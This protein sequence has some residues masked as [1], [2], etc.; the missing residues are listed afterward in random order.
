MNMLLLLLLS[1]LLLPLNS[2]SYTHKEQ[3]RLLPRTF[4]PRATPASLEARP[5]SIGGPCGR[6]IYLH[7]LLF[8]QKVS[9]IQNLFGS[10]KRFKWISRVWTFEQTFFWSACF[11]DPRPPP[12]RCYGSLLAF[13]IWCLVF[14]LSDF[15]RC[16]ID[17]SLKV[18]VWVSCV[19]HILI[20]VVFAILRIDGCLSSTLWTVFLASPKRATWER[21]DVSVNNKLDILVMLSY[22]C[23]RCIVYYM[24][25]C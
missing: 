7:C 20:S 12:R 24:H 18:R 3:L 4:A 14:F 10:K 2:D 22:T 6:L 5:A 23:T 8:E 1:L 13:D 17:R 9:S 16:R 25:V 21:A 11:V 15:G 19:V